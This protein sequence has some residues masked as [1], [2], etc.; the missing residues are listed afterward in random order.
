MATFCFHA[1]ADS[2]TY[3]ASGVAAHGTGFTILG[4]YTTKEDGSVEYHF[5]RVYAAR[6]KKTY[7][8]GTLDEDGVTLS[9]TWGY[10]DDKRPYEFWFKR[11]APE[12]LIARPPPAEFKENKVRALWSYALTYARNEAQ[13]K[14]WSW[15]HFKKRRDIRKEYLELLEREVD[16]LSTDNDLDRFAYLDR[17]A[18]YDDTRCFYV[19]QD[20]RQRPKPAHLYVLVS[21]PR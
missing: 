19:L 7:F 1:S 14:L 16:D 9:G 20:Y 18:T 15:S 17:T 12:I 6:M 10:S 11:T 2:N 5:S 21:T 13:R 4:G 3:E 8:R